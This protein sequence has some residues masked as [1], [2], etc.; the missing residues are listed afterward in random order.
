MCARAV[1]EIPPPSG[2]PKDGQPATGEEAVRPLGP[3]SLTWQYF[4]DLRVILLGLRAGLLQLLHP[5]LGAGV[6]Q[7]SVLYHAPWERLFRS[8]F[9]IMRVVYNEQEA[10]KVA[11]GIRNMHRHINGNDHHGRAY[12]ALDPSI[13]FWAHATIFE[14]MVKMVD[15]FDHPLTQDEK[16]RLYEES[17]RW[18][19]LYGAPYAEMP[20]TWEEFEAY[21]DRMCNE[22][23]EPTPAAARLLEM[24]NH[25]ESLKQPFLPDAVW[26]RISP[27]AMAMA[28]FLARGTMPPSVRSKMGYAWSPREDRA[29][30]WVALGISRAWPLL[31]MLLRM[32][33]PARRALTRA[34]ASMWS[35]ARNGSAHLSR[36]G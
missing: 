7:H 16:R 11:T 4:G 13:F 6:E 19:R 1:S 31:P 35:T 20:K 30:R 25:P 17:C 26:R 33:A 36:D 8:V 9:P 24:V 2:K 22:V 32:N 28:W 29:F 18:Y 27:P 14:A 34:G 21:F 15:V 10:E 23:L 5:G 12:R 3:D